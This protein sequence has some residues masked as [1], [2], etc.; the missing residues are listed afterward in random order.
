MD[1]LRGGTGAGVGEMRGREK[2]DRLGTGKGLVGHLRQPE[3]SQAPIWLAP[4]LRPL[5]FSAS[6]G[7]SVPAR[8]TFSIAAL[9]NG[10]LKTSGPCK[11][12][13]PDD[14]DAAQTVLE[15]EVSVHEVDA[16][17]GHAHAMERVKH[18]PALH[19]SEETP[20]GQDPPTFTAGHLMEED[21]K[22]HLATTEPGLFRGAS[23]QMELVLQPSM[24]D[25]GSARVSSV[26]VIN[27]QSLTVYGASCEK[28]N[29][30]NGCGSNVGKESSLR[31]RNGRSD[32]GICSTVACHKFMSELHGKP[33][34]S[35]TAG[36]VMLTSSHDEGMNE[37]CPVSDH[38]PSTEVYI[39]PEDLVC[40]VAQGEDCYKSEDLN[41]QK[42]ETDA[43]ALACGIGMMPKAAEYGERRGER[44][45]IDRQGY[46]MQI[47]DMGCGHDSAKDHMLTTC[48]QQE[49]P[50]RRADRLSCEDGVDQETEGCVEQGAKN[51]MP[52]GNGQR[53]AKR[54][55]EDLQPGVEEGTVGLSVTAAEALVIRGMI[56]TCG[57]GM[58]WDIERAAIE[59]AVRL[60]RNRQEMQLDVYSYESADTVY[61]AGDEDETEILDEEMEDAFKDVGLSISRVAESHH[62]GDVACCKGDQRANLA[63]RICTEHL[64]NQAHDGGDDD[65]HHE[66]NDGNGDALYQDNVHEGTPLD[67]NCFVQS[68]NRNEFQYKKRGRLVKGHGGG[69]GHYDE[70]FAGEVGTASR[71]KADGNGLSCQ[72]GSQ[73]VERVTCCDKLETA[74]GKK[75][76]PVMGDNNCNDYA[77]PRRMN[78]GYNA[79]HENE[80]GEDQRR[81]EG[82]IDDVNKVKVVCAEDEIDES[83]KEFQ[84]CHQGRATL[85]GNEP[86]QLEM[87]ARLRN[88][89]CMNPLIAAVGSVQMS[90]SVS[91]VPDTCPESVDVE[92]RDQ[93]GQETADVNEVDKV[94]YCERKL[95]ELLPIAD[96]TAAMMT[97]EP[98]KKLMVHS[99]SDLRATADVIESAGMKI[100]PRENDCEGETA[101]VARFSGEQFTKGCGFD[102]SSHSRSVQS[103][104]DAHVE[105]IG[106]SVKGGKGGWSAV[107]TGGR[108]AEVEGPAENRTE[109]ITRKHSQ[110]MNAAVESAEIESQKLFVCGLL[111]NNEQLSGKKEMCTTLHDEFKDARRAK[112]VLEGNMNAGTPEEVLEDVYLLETDMTSSDTYV[113]MDISPGPGRDLLVEKRG[114]KTH[115]EEIERA[116]KAAADKDAQIMMSQCVDMGSFSGCNQETVMRTTGN[117]VLSEAITRVDGMGRMGRYDQMSLGLSPDTED[118]FAG[119]RRKFPEQE[120]GRRMPRE[121]SVRRN[122]VAGISTDNQMDSGMSGGIEDT[123][124]PDNETCAEEMDRGAQ[125]EA[126]ETCGNLGAKSETCAEEMDRDAQ[127]EAAIET[128]VDNRHDSNAVQPRCKRVGRL[129]DRPAQGITS[130]AGSV[131]RW[132]GGWSLIPSPQQGRAPILLHSMG[133]VDLVEGIQTPRG[134]VE[135]KTPSFSFQPFNSLLNH[136]F[137]GVD[138]NISRIA[139]TLLVESVADVGQAVEATEVI[140]S[141]ECDSSEDIQ[142]G[143]SCEP[144]IVGGVATRNRGQDLDPGSGTDLAIIQSTQ[145]SVS[146]LPLSSNPL[147]SFVPCTPCDISQVE[148]SQNRT[149]QLDLPSPSAAPKSPADGLSQGRN[150]AWTNTDTE[151]SACRIQDRGHGAQEKEQGRTCVM[152]LR[153][154]TEDVEEEWEGRRCRGKEQENEVTGVVEMT[155]HNMASWKA[156][157]HTEAHCG[158]QLLNEG[159]EQGR[160]QGCR[161]ELCN[162]E[163]GEKEGRKHEERKDNFQVV[164]EEVVI[165]KKTCKQQAVPPHAA[166]R[167]SD[168]M[169]K[170]VRRKEPRCHGE[171][172]DVQ[173]RKWKERKEQESAKMVGESD[174]RGQ[175]LKEKATHQ[176]QHEENMQTDNHDEE[177]VPNANQDGGGTGVQETVATTSDSR[178]T[179]RLQ[180]K[181]DASPSAMADIA[182]RLEQMATLRD[183][184]A[185]LQPEGSRM[186]PSPESG[187]EIHQQRHHGHAMSNAMG[188][189]LNPKQKG[190]TNDRE[191]DKARTNG[192]AQPDVPGNCDKEFQGSAT[193]QQHLVRLTHKH[194]STSG[195]STARKGGIVLRPSNSRRV[196]PRR[197]IVKHRAA[198]SDVRPSRHLYRWKRP[199]KAGPRTPPQDRKGEG[200]KDKHVCMEDQVEGIDMMRAISSSSSPRGPN[201]EDKGDA[202]GR[203]SGPSLMCWLSKVGSKRKRQVES[204]EVEGGCHDEEDHD[205][206]AVGRE[207]DGSRDSV[208]GREANF[209]FQV[210]T[211]QHT[212]EGVEIDVLERT[213]G[214]CTV[215][216]ASDAGNADAM[217]ISKATN[218]NQNRDSNC[219]VAVEVGSR[220]THKMRELNFQEQNWAQNE[221][222][223]E[224]GACSS[225][226]HVAGHCQQVGVDEASSVGTLN[227]WPNKSLPSSSS[228]RIRGV[229]EEDVRSRDTSRNP[230][231]EEKSK[232]SIYTDRRKR[233]RMSPSIAPVTPA[234]PGHQGPRRSPTRRQEN[235]QQGREDGLTRPSPG[236]QGLHRSSTRMQENA[237][238]RLEDM[239][240][241]SPGRQGLCRSSTRMQENVQQRLKDTRVSIGIGGRG[242]DWCSL[243]GSR[244]CRRELLPD[245]NRVAKDS[246]P[247]KTGG[248]IGVGGGVSDTRKGRKAGMRVCRERVGKHHGKLDKQNN[249]E[250]N[251]MADTSERNKHQHLFKGMRF[252]LTG[253]DSQAK[254]NLLE[255]ITSD[256]GLVLS[257]I[258]HAYVV[259][260]P[261]SPHTRRQAEGLSGHPHVIAARKLRTPKFL[262]GYAVGIPPASSDWIIQSVKARALLPVSRIAVRARPAVPPRPKRFSRQMTPAASSTTLTVQDTT[263][264][265]PAC[266]V[267]EA[268]EP[269]ADYRGLLQAFTDAVAAAEAQQ[270]AAEAERMRLANEAAGEAQRTTETDEAAR[271]R[272]NAASTE[273]LIASEHQWATLLQGMIFVPTETQAE[274]TQAEAEESN[275]ATVMLNVMRGVM[276]NNKLLQAHLH[277]ERQQR[278][279]Y[280]Q[281]LAAVTADVRNA[282]MQQQQQQQ[283]MNSTIARINGIEAKAS[284][285]PGCTTDAA[286]QINERID[287]VVTI[288]GDI[289]V[290]NGPDTISSTVAAIKT[291]I[292]KLQTR[293]DAATKTF[294]MPHFDITR[295]WTTKWQKI[296]TTPGFDLTFPNQ[297]SE[298]F[299]RSCAGLRST[300][301][302]EYDYTTFQGILDRANLV[303]QTDHKAANERQSQPHYV[304]KQAYQRLTHNNAVISEET[305]DHHAAAA[306][307]SDGGIVVALPPKRPKRVRKNKATQE[308]AAAG[309]GQPWTAYKITK[310]VYDLRQKFQWGFE[311][312]S[313]EKGRNSLVS[314]RD[315]KRK[316]ESGTVEESSEVAQ[317]VH[318]K[319]VGT[320]GCGLI[321][322]TSGALLSGL[323]ILLRG[324]SKFRNQLELLIQHAGARVVHSL[325]S[326]GSGSGKGGDVPIQERACDYVV[327]QEI[328]Q[329]QPDFLRTARR[330]KVHVVT[331]D[332][333]IQALLMRRLPAQRP[334]E[335]GKLGHKLLQLS[336]PQAKEAAIPSHER[337]HRQEK[338]VEAEED[339]PA[340]GTPVVGGAHNTERS[341]QRCSP[342]NI[343]GRSPEMSG[344][345]LMTT[346][347]VSNLVGTAQVE[348][349]SP[350]RVG[351]AFSEQVPSHSPGNQAACSASGIMP[352]S[353]VT[354]IPGRSRTERPVVCFSGAASGD[355]SRHAL[356]KTKPCTEASP[357]RR[358]AR[359]PAQ[360]ANPN[361]SGAN[362]VSFSPP[363]S[364]KKPSAARG[365]TIAVAINE[366]PSERPAARSSGAACGDGSRRCAVKKP[367]PH[368]EASPLR[369]SPWHPAEQADLDA[370]DANPVSSSPPVCLEKPSTACGTT[371]AVAINVRSSKGPAACSSGAVEKSKPCPETS[372]LRRS[373]RFPAQQANLD[374]S[375]TH[376]VSL[377]APVCLEKP[378][379]ARGTAIGTARNGRSSERPAACPSGAASGDG[380][381]KCAVERTTTCPEASPPRRSP[382]HPAQQ[383]NLE[384]SDANPVCLSQPVC[385]GQPSASCDAAVGATVRGEGIAPESGRADLDILQRRCSPRFLRHDSPSRDPKSASMADILRHSHNN[386]LPSTR[387]HSPA[388]LRKCAVSPSACPRSL[389]IHDTN[390]N[391]SKNGKKVQVICDDADQGSRGKDE[392][393]VCPGEVS[394][395]EQRDGQR[396]PYR[397]QKDMGKV[398]KMTK[399]KKTADTRT[400]DNGDDGSDFEEDGKGKG[401]VLRTSQH[402]E[403]KGASRPQRDL[404]RAPGSEGGHKGK[405]DSGTG[406]WR[407]GRQQDMEKRYPC[408]WMGRCS[409]RPMEM[410]S[411]GVSNS[412]VKQVKQR[413]KPEGVSVIYYR[414]FKCNGVV[415]EL[416]DT[417]EASRTTGH[418]RQESP[419]VLRIE[420][421]WEEFELTSHKGARIGCQTLNSSEN[422]EDCH[423]SVSDGSNLQKRSGLSVFFGPLAG[424]IGAFLLEESSV[425]GKL[426]FIFFHLFGSDVSV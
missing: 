63:D 352:V 215:N 225:A 353:P 261:Q 130:Q 146:M 269:L 56:E 110:C 390:K 116:D 406:K 18:N 282:A 385:L 300:L 185:R 94:N 57:G 214:S 271:N 425:L 198:R 309:A 219:L 237:Q 241:P 397:K 357:L 224:Q 370:S 35:E 91:V 344:P 349:S 70:S 289:G 173:V 303:I 338:K 108:K 174:P 329:M 142:A 11:S 189:G 298:F 30:F 111:P 412:D 314:A 323:R 92:S 81:D 104:E 187:E 149:F 203:D 176:E 132:L 426:S 168:S 85:T 74:V 162:I 190:R 246:R 200:R 413:G 144:C 156:G 13:E 77:A 386:P 72:S 359:S 20:V 334:I 382:R 343:A 409:R 123:F 249:T 118:A 233:R 157:T 121:I 267:Q 392:Q 273:S 43:R 194:L 38:T 227:E 258:P 364:L 107:A 159:Q 217:E 383:A 140:H 408:D 128:G 296:V 285:A 411:L 268:S 147:C 102:I 270:A 211:S 39:A 228:V 93:T 150:S 255:T 73:E 201:E 263:G 65:D 155:D 82:G 5:S 143:G 294:K 277:A 321:A 141:G 399:G 55:G 301:G 19:L 210:H 295:D 78:N 206:S 373:P 192:M 333:V 167:K 80:V 311:E 31:S 345:S 346:G 22:P 196:S 306:S 151:R 119:R 325:T 165:Q 48:R 422:P 23:T 98:R 288:I 245:E 218:A 52:Y 341:P 340:P 248:M 207:G 216:A 318:R 232:K 202:A 188:P 61:Y 109:S 290:F 375:D 242:V 302:N 3:F 351:A 393:R 175:Q 204:D 172:V 134:R 6:L 29:K 410:P 280:Q 42:P 360:Q 223:H 328:S 250:A 358:S 366:R 115:A 404:K 158:R 191:Q 368:S 230:E 182:D 4:W 315:R 236:R 193:G 274:P 101:M 126:V 265:L 135:D 319:T 331:Y 67:N 369:R 154:E 326:G 169:Q 320:S 264:D 178:M 131:S 327:V 262:F 322:G 361:A 181:D 330:M 25:G 44:G 355:G 90:S 105:G 374:A 213:G 14:M 139:S 286:K 124:R 197:Q 424:G 1:G 260:A 276:W 47:E 46:V 60:R 96:G 79:G 377:S 117:Q 414:A 418:Q 84:D 100:T 75:A 416:G 362:P 28:Q 259:T 235:A 208:S 337:C 291:D 313:D 8:T 171:D 160:K 137:P 252:L 49:V 87:N 120:I 251:R 37:F 41:C 293:P 247:D 240:T 239:L 308:T 95:G 283:L 221:G 356:Q 379:A 53:N 152:D 376:P 226:A 17:R 125:N 97:I 395:G 266:P 127:N 66:F 305:D 9:N 417:V 163:G 68:D 421:L 253:F 209:V 166:P 316:G 254:K 394:E 405:V 284:A 335:D 372:P 398:S 222:V 69:G 384:A 354:V 389:R 106:R 342:L 136:G 238:Q 205:A 332:C 292:T 347:V 199:P 133:Q 234:S 307:S 161:Q 33:C 420:E 396:M 281:D 415:F 88:A 2:E 27:G 275:L 40:S 278:Q 54:R 122:D 279:Q 34:G 403:S 243:Q 256:G 212:G 400:D 62:S 103:N 195:R 381:R 145:S 45:V 257:E 378:S 10:E 299:S 153:L 244:T 15:S 367:K 170:S 391:L 297:R 113:D 177:S 339:V 64:E 423:G 59:I 312:E 24:Q 50:E 184:T 350:H 58:K 407:H 272:R 26:R 419:V 21:G 32:S 112:A 114:R 180:M 99:T 129:S 348:R 138:P 324:T 12:C 229:G 183:S 186:S 86:E 89:T 371:I 380:P 363:M 51:D 401:K 7:D 304:A 310:E 231:G 148:S 317:N 83:V 76:M 71:L 388:S 402:V 287:H 36:C 336:P 179:M 220:S 365:A 164:E 16:V 387:R